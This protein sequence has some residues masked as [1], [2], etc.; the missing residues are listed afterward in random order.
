MAVPGH[1][2]E[3]KTILSLSAVLVFPQPDTAVMFEK[4]GPGVSSGPQ[5]SAQ[6]PA[7]GRTGSFQTSFNIS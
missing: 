3:E 5:L 1:V 7:Q 6:R 2:R 4:R